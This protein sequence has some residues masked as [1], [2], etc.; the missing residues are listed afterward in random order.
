MCERQYI[1]NF[2]NEQ[3]VLFWLSS[4]EGPQTEKEIFSGLLSEGFSF[5]E[6]GIRAILQHALMRGR[7][8]TDNKV[9]GV[10]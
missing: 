8:V 1:W 5:D 10:V 4:Q 3:A 6:F 2:N 9:W 7:V